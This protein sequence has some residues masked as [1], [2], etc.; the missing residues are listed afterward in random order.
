MPTFSR[1][2][3][4]RSR[5][6]SRSSPCRRRCTSVE[7]ISDH[8]GRIERRHRLLKHHRHPGAAQRSK[9]LLRRLRKIMPLERHSMRLAGR[10]TRRQAHEQEARSS[11]SRGRTRRRDTASR[12]GRSRGEMPRTACSV[13]R[14]VAR[15]TVRFSTSNREGHSAPPAG[16]GDIADAIADHV[17]G[18]HQPAARAVPGIAISQNREE[19][20]GLG[21]CDHQAPRGQRRLRAETEEQSAASIKIALAASTSRGRSIPAARW[22]ALRPRSRRRSTRQRLPQLPRSRAPA[23]AA[24]PLA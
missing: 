2:S 20:V 7:L 3:T 9:L 22:A 4:A 1:S 15:S 18:E 14:G 21:L 16:R 12:R 11:T 5:A 17:G 24:S 10:R 13:P 8:V 19:Q 23:P 6:A